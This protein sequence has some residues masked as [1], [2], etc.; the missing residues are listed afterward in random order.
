[1]KW[2]GCL[3]PGKWSLMYGLDIVN[4]CRMQKLAVVN[5]QQLTGNGKSRVYMPC[6]EAPEALFSI[7]FHGFFTGRVDANPWIF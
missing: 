1:M 4:N 7:Q 6:F 3:P 5:Y 2:Q